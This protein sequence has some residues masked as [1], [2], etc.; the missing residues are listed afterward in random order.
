MGLLEPL[1]KQPMVLNDIVQFWSNL[2]RLPEIY[3]DVFEVQDFS[4]NSS[5]QIDV[6]STTC[7]HSEYIVEAD[8]FLS[9]E[10]FQED[11]IWKQNKTAIFNINAVISI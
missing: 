8:E 7:T 9:E 1:R 5:I 3:V 10:D 4:S 2:G 6:A 11:E